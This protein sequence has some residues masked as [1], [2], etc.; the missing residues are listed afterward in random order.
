M[1]VLELFRLEG[2]K[3]VV[4]GASRGLGFEM[5]RALAEAGA[6]VVVSSRD[7][8]KLATAVAELSA[9][10]HSALGVVADLSE[11]QAAVEFCDQVLAD[12][13]PVDILVNNVGGRRINY[14]TEE[15]PE[16]EWRQ[17]LDLNLTQ[18]FICTKRIGGAMLA[19]GRGRVINVTSISA[20]V[21]GRQMRGRSYETAKAALT[22]FTKS[23]AAD[24]ARSGVTVN[25]IAPGPFLTDANRR[26]FHEKPELK[27][28]IEATIPMGR[29]GEPAEI[30]PLC[31]YLAS[32]ASSYMTGS[33]L[34]IDG[35]RLLW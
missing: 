26:W 27:D 29:M 33:I 30:G 25:A 32:D 23:V 16:D 4:T 24:W 35:G 2:R 7:A 10:G 17:M 18:A 21:A 1:S 15:F 3:A 9:A 6:A 19:R 28:E 5:A 20:F 8:G 13:G 12:H 14:Q 31:V 34:V 22:M 11:P